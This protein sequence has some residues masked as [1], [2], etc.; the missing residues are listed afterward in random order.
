MDEVRIVKAG[1]E[2]IGRLEPLWKA[3]HAHHLSVDPRLPGIPIRSQEEAW[4]RRRRLYEGWLSETDAF[5]L[6]AECRERTVGYALAHM[7]EADES[8]DTRGR[9]GVLESL[10]VLPE[11]RRLGVGRKLMSA[12]YAELRR[13]GVS[14][15]EIGVLATNRGARRFY[16][17]EGFAPWV[18]HYLGIVPGPPD[19]G[20]GSA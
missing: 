6:A 5:L 9:F 17:R 12:L 13:L 16:E 1:A 14:V 7:H 18:T 10:A 11:M 3:L 20:A 15:L 8:W 19:P 4:A 2:R